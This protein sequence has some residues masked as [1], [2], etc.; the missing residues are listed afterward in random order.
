MS[1]P[2]RKPSLSGLYIVRLFDGFDLLW[3]DIGKPAS[4][5]E[6]LALWNTKTNGGTEATRF[7]DIDYYDIFPAH[8]RMMLRSP[9]A[10]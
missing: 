10:Q 7:G 6:A 4:W 8:T 1:Q 9:S 5:D 3:I 2:Y